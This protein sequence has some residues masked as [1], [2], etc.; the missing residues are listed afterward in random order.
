MKLQIIAWRIA[1]IVAS[2]WPAASLPDNFI[3]KDFVREMKPRKI[4]RI[5]ILV[6]KEKVTELEYIKKGKCNSNIKVLL[7]DMRIL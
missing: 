7:L 1:A 2:F 6:K 3:G 5:F 4:Q